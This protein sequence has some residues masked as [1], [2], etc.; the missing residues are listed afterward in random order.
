MGDNRGKRSNR[1]LPGRHSSS[2]GR[3]VELAL[4]LT[5]ALLVLRYTPFAHVP[6]SASF[7]A[8]HGGYMFDFYV[9]MAV[10]VVG[11]SIYLYCFRRKQQ[12]AELAAVKDALRHGR[13][14][15]M[16]FAARWLFILGMLGLVVLGW[17][18]PEPHRARILFIAVPLFLLFCAVELNII[19]HPGETH[20]PDPRDE[21]LAFFKARMLQAGYVASIAALVVLYLTYLF[22]PMYVGLLLPAV[23]AACLL[24]PSVVYNRLDHQ[25]GSDG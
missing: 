9:Y 16:S 6:G 11:K 25:A 19:V 12:A 23:L 7:E 15:R 22:A 1:P 17:L 21:L 10:W 2:W 20:F 13:V 3:W 5:G 18:A 4:T 8:R 24:I 14:K